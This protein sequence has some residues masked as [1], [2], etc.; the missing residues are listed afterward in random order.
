MATT[1]TSK[2]RTVESNDQK[3]LQNYIALVTGANRGIG[4]EICR[5]LAKQ[6]YNVILTS[7]VK[8]EGLRAV[9]KLII[10]KSITGKIFFH[11]LDVTDEQSINNIYN[12]ICRQYDRLD[13]L[14]NNAGIYLD[15]GKSVFDISEDIMRKT[16]EV[17]F[18]GAFRICRKF[19]PLMRQNGF[20]RIVNVSSGYGAM[21]EMGGHT[22]AYRISK[23]ALNALTLIIA[24]EL[25]NYSSI[26]V[27]AVCPGWVSTDMGGT[28]APISPRTAAEDIVHFATIDENGPTGRFF[29]FRK[30]IDW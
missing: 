29:R 9:E 16:M 20:G 18:Y 10:D 5:S 13:I 4:Y 17:N 7:R 14:V 21:N 27:N 6:G 26:K 2:K 30:E 25:K 28:M 3:H 24:D 1:A 12:W 15:E 19:I 22:A 11:I 8:D 23:T